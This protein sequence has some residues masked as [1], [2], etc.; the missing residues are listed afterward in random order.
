MGVCPK[1]VV[2]A[3]DSALKDSYSGC[4]MF[5]FNS[6]LLRFRIA[7]AEKGSESYIYVKNQDESR[8]KGSIHLPLSETFKAESGALTMFLGH[9]PTTELGAPK[10]QICSNYNK[11]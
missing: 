11:R 3:P 6:C 1:T 5:L 2:R 4:F 10:S 7:E 8:H 9:T